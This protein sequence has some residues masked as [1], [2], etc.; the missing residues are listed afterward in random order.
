MQFTEPSIYTLTLPRPCPRRCGPGR[1]L[2]PRVT[3]RRSQGRVQ[4]SRRRRKPVELLM[5]SPSDRRG[6][7]LLLPVTTISFIFQYND[8]EQDLSSCILLPVRE[9]D[10]AVDDL[11]IHLALLQFLLPVLRARFPSSSV[12]FFLYL[13]LVVF[14]ESILGRTTAL[15][16]HIS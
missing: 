4:R 14:E 10:D 8:A 2:A 9:R 6:C 16:Y 12:Y 13:N 7:S 11:C 1:R 3:R 5:S 15:G